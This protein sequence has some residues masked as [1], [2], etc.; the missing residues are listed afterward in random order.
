VGAWYAFL[1][2]PTDSVGGMKTLTLEINN[3]GPSYGPGMGVTLS[4]LLQHQ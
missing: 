4:L 1:Q 3:T 2:T